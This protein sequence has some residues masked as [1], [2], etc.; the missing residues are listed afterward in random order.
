MTASVGGSSQGV[1]TSG[2]G[3]GSGSG[4][5]SGEGGG[6]FFGIATKGRRVAYVVDCSGS[7]NEPH[8]SPA[9]TR[10]RRLQ[11]ELLAV[12]GAMTEDDEFFIIFF[13]SRP[14]P[15][16]ATAMQR[17]LPATRAA[18]LQWMAGQHAQGDTDPRQALE[19]ALRLEPDVVYFLSDGEFDRRIKRDL[20]KVAQE[21]VAINTIA[22]GERGGEEVLKGIAERN[23]GEYR[24]IP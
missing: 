10:F 24:Y 16:P 7:M 6:G 2:S 15:M 18:Y 23:G 3:T 14:I 9:R 17:A 5:G 11:L 8:A 1:G 4:A 13:N 12:I 22:F 21:D 20:D 19:L